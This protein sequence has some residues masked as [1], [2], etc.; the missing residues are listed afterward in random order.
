MV[1]WARWFMEIGTYSSED[2]KCKGEFSWKTELWTMK[3]IAVGIHIWRGKN[4]FHIIIKFLSLRQEIMHKAYHVL[5]QK[6]WHF[7]V[8]VQNITRAEIVHCPCHLIDPVWFFGFIRSSSYV[9]LR[10]FTS[11]LSFALNLYPSC[12]FF[13]LLSLCS[14]CVMRTHV[15]LT[16]QQKTISHNLSS[17]GE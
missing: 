7:T 4:V 11:N 17:T 9:H 5:N 10:L 12:C 6:R 15:W 1:H 8:N 3:V 2:V 13:K 16:L 14:L